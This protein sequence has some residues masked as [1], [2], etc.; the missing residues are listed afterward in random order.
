MHAVYIVSERLKFNKV[1]AGTLPQFALTGSCCRDVRFRDYAPL[2]I[3]DGANVSINCA[4]G[5]VN[6]WHADRGIMLGSNS[7]LQFR[8]CKVSTFRDYEEA[9]SL[10]DDE[11]HVTY[12]FGNNLE[13]TI[14][15]VNSELQ[16]TCK[17]CV[18]V[19]AIELS[20]NFSNLPLKP[21][22]QRTLN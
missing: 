14:E 17:V 3:P 15:V 6:T 5:G 11:N 9:A 8:D 12:M 1:I 21:W 19:L 22:P 10:G 7:K 18:I 2:S 4:S 20:A 16:Q 13:A